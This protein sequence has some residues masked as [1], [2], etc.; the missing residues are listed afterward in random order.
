[1]STLPPLHH[2]GYVVDDLKASVEAF[3]ARHA[4]GPFFAIKHLEFDEVTYLG[5]VAV[6]DHSS[7]FG[8]WGPLIV[9]LTQVHD[10]RPPGLREA[11]VAPGGGIGHIAWLA[12]SLDAESERLQAAGM[13]PF[14]SGRSGPVRVVWFD[15]ARLFG[16]PV[17]VL[18]RCEEVLGF[19]AA[20]AAA[21]QGWDG[22]RPFRSAAEV[23]G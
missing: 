23:L 6:Y 21:A 18:E 12:D 22:Q 3:A 19:H 7:A 20:I 17:E 14:H 1:M 11:L 10:A 15:S 13:R 5:E 4:A 2:I 8:Q 9:E 16:H